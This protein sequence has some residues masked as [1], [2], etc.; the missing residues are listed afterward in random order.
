[1]FSLMLDIGVFLFVLVAVGV[2]V[3]VV[4]VVELLGCSIPC[5]GDL[6]AV[7]FGCYCRFLFLFLL[8]LLQYLCA[9]VYF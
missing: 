9:E 6:C 5:G 3:L 7:V 2:V 1:M 4:S 8:F